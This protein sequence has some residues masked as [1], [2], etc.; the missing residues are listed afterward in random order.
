M[1]VDDERLAR[2]RLAR[3]L[4]EL[5]CVVLAELRNS[6]ALIE[7]MEAKEPA[8]ALFLD[9]QMP[10]GSG[11]ELLAELRDPP[12]VIFVTA[13]AEHAVRAFDAD[14]V[15]YVLKPVFKDRLE[16]ALM[17][18]RAKLVPRRSGHELRA[19]TTDGPSLR[20]P[21]KAGD[22]KLLLDLRK[23]SHFEVEDE[24]V[25]AW[26]GGKRFRTRWTALSEVEQEIRDPGFMR[27]QRGILAKPAMILGIRSLPGGRCKVR[28]PEGVELEVSRSATPAIRALC[29]L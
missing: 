21:V 12:P 16:R 2:E 24:I 14:A 6:R 10:G 17:R 27:I 20:I 3:L 19:L 8:D 9:I 1:V 4:R 22:G 25:W 5:E 28:F 13:H 26:A 29:G 15:D 23:I 7:W 11:L 18:L